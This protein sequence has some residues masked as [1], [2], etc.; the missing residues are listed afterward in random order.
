[1]LSGS[2]LRKI[3]SSVIPKKNEDRSHRSGL[4]FRYLLKQSLQ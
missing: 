1:M 2:V 4:P 3:I